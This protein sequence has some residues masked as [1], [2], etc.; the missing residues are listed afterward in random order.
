MNIKDNIELNFRRLNEKEYKK[1]S[2]FQD[3]AYGWPGDWEGRALLAFCCHYEMS[4]R[5]TECLENFMSE[6]KPRLNGK[7][8]LGKEFDGITADEQQ[9]SGHS[10]LLRGMM[11]YYEL[12][13]D[14]FALRVA[15]STVWNLFLCT[16]QNFREYPF[17]RQESQGGV[18]GNIS[19]QT[20]G[21][22]LSSDIGCGFIGVD[23]LSHYYSVT[24]DEKTKEFIDF[25]IRLFMG[26]DVYA[27]R[28]QTH[29]TL[30]CLRGILRMYES[31][32][33]KYYLDCVRKV[34]DI[35][36]EHG[37]TLTYANFN[38]FG[39]QDSWT[40]PCAVVDSF[41]LALGLY[42]ATGEMKYKTLARRIWFHGLQFCLRNN[43]GTGPDTCVTTKSNVLQVSMFE[44][45]F[46][47]TMRYAEG[48]LYALKN[49]VLLGWDE[50][51][52][53]ITDEY[54]RR[55]VDDR[56]I[57][58]YEGKSLPIFTAA[59]LGD[60]DSIMRAKLKIF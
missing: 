48:L 28:F 54:G 24:G 56:L 59:E 33:H 23:G 57:V 4:G 42:S 38:W 35:Y 29:A 2:V 17:T 58:E 52:E 51:A 26:A 18:S 9:L 44:A 7:S 21:W 55:L 13:G 11:K 47:C 49:E 34:F 41:I 22:K 53:Q 27:Y 1:E 30:S 16:E 6:L 31:T 36:T 5:K 32:G 37:M 15:E 25:L 10:W 3:G 19:E 45:P 39:R 50:N 20:R 14:I 8:Y 12:F 43:G 46:C 60:C 40:E